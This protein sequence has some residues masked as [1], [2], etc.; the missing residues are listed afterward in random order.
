MSL[1]HNRVPQ[2]FEFK[3]CEARG[4]IEYS[5]DKIT[6]NLNK[7]RVEKWLDPEEP[8]RAALVGYLIV[9]CGYPPNRI[10]LEV[11]VPRRTTTDKADIVVFKDDACKDPYIVCETKRDGVSRRERDQGIEQGIGNALGLAAP[12]AVYF[13]YG[14]EYCF[15]TSS[16]SAALERETNILGGLMSVPRQYLDSDPSFRYIA[17]GRDG[18]EDI[19]PATTASI[20]SKV[21]RTHSIIWAGG[22]RDPLTS[23]DEWSKLLFAKVH[24]ERTTKNGYPR[25]FQAGPS[26]TKTTV[27]NRVHQLF[28]EAA[29]QDETIFTHGVRIT[30]SDSKIYEI[31]Q[32][33]Q[34]IS[35]T[36]SKTDTIGRA[37]ES[38]FGRVF[39]G[40]LGQYFTMRE[41]SRFT[42]AALEIED[43]DY[44]IDPTAGSG[45]FLLE[46]LLQGWRKIASDYAG[47]HEVERKR[48]DFAH[49]HVFGIEINEILGRILKINLLLHHDGH[50]NIESDRTCLDA[51]FS[52]KPLSAKMKSGFTRVVGNPPFGDKVKRGDMDLLGANTLDSFVLGKGKSQI[53]SEHIIIERSVDMLS[54]G[55]RLGFVI[56]DGILNNSGG[57]S[58]CP[59]VREYLLSQGKIDMIVSLPDYA[60]RK[61]GAQNKTSILFFRKFTDQEK[62]EFDRGFSSTSPETSGMLSGI[63]SI[64]YPVFFAEANFIG[65][66]PR[67]AKIDQNDLYNSNQQGDLVPDQEG[68]ILGEYKKFQ[69]EGIDYGTRTKPDCVAL[70][71]SD[72]WEAHESHR[73]D[74]KFHIFKN[75]QELPAKQGWET[76]SLGDVMTRRREQVLPAESPDQ[77]FNVLSL[78]QEGV[79]T[80][81]E[82]G[83]GQAPPEWRG[84]YFEDMPT[85]W[86]RVRAGDL[87]YSSIDLWKGCVS[88]VDPEHDGGLVSSE[89]PI[90]RVDERIDPDFLAVLL[91]SRYYQ[92]AFRA[93]TTGHSN[94][95]RTQISD[96]ERLEIQYPSDL[97]IQASLASSVIEARNEQRTAGVNWRARLLEFSDQIDGRG[98]EVLAEIVEE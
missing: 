11:P 4:F 39:R 54:P 28:L 32:V 8:V 66:N 64:D 98:S 10:Q 94:R 17:G 67:G 81:R 69:D 31:V 95:R 89:F 36:N 73:L 15:D 96:F 74:P 19:Q 84:M 92:R 46:V 12:Y 75:V 80:A 78:S 50:T 77:I 25:K 68:T 83:K 57:Q 34:S 37:F 48:Y 65:Y 90:F 27:A 47:Q 76:H 88:I 42:V 20:E 43:N 82:A 93:I 45:G 58:G 40:E 79:L 3:E 35:I 51:K 23:F 87:V 1:L 18:N 24:D 55:G 49:L 59:A 60:F 13:D 86:Y 70:M 30:L 38:F 71:I 52:N 16:R 6:Y 44:I 14:T 53:Q 62:I 26:E 72:V 22:K 33:L 41:L 56:P 61:S 7:K 63:R 21:R 5:A 85:K 9:E 2:T 29:E 97:A 91:R